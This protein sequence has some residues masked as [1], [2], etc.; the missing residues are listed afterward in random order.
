MLKK[1]EMISYNVVENVVVL[2]KVRQ[3]SIADRNVNLK[4]E[5]GNLGLHFM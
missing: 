3:L 4:I 1:E 2:I 5:V